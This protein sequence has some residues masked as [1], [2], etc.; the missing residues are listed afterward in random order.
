VHRRD[1]TCL[2]TRRPEEICPDTL[3]LEGKM[4]WR[5]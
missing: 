4:P 5:A 2:D 3:R 1:A